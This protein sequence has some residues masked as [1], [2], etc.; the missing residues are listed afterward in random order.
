MKAGAAPAHG[1]I[2]SIMT[3]S[4]NRPLVMLVFF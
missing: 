3:V 1:G 4:A 2:V